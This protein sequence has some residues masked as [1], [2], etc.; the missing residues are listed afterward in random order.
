[1]GFE[2]TM[3]AFEREKTVHTLDRSATVIGFHIVIFS[4]AL[5]AHSG[6]WPLILFRNHFLKTVGLL[7]RVIS[8]S[9]G[10]YLNT[11]QH[12]HRIK[13]YTHTPNIHALSGIQTHYPRV[14]ASEDSSCLRPRGYGFHIL[15]LNLN[16]NMTLKTSF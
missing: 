7:G 3:P 15:I 6:P 14:E 10:L 2:P 9:Q 16:K 13:A 12:R 11:G 8:P 5:P 4:M 1:M